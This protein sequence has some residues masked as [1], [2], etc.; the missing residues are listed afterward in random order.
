MVSVPLLSLT[1]SCLS[2]IVRRAW[3]LGSLAGV[4]ICSFLCLHKRASQYLLC[5][6]EFWTKQMKT[7][8]DRKKP[9]WKSP[10]PLHFIDSTDSLA[11]HSDL[12]TAE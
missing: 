9:L 8:K 1:I 11:P 12:S 3:G 7:L 10:L 5:M 4:L 2:P 6:G